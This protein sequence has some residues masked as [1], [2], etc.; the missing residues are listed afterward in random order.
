MVSMTQT[1]ILLRWKNINMSK[2]DINWVKYIGLYIL[3]TIVQ[4]H[5]RIEIN[6][7]VNSLVFLSL[8]MIS[9]EKEK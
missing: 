2:Y 1:Q 3:S 9:T 7:F 8:M 4:F 5:F 6:F